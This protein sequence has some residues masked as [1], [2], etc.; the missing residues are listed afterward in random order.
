MVINN[1]VR[2]FFCKKLMDFYRWSYFGFRQSLDHRRWRFQKLFRHFFSHHSIRISKVRNE[3]RKSKKDAGKYFQQLKTSFL[4]AICPPT[5]TG[6]QPLS[7]L[8]FINEWLY[9]PS[10]VFSFPRPSWTGKKTLFPFQW[11]CLPQT[12]NKSARNNMSWTTCWNLSFEFWSTDFAIALSGNRLVMYFYTFQP[13]LPGLWPAATQTSPTTAQTATTTTTASSASTDVSGF[14]GFRRSQLCRRRN[15]PA[16]L[17]R[18]ETGSR[19][20][21]LLFG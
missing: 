1:T 2:S 17:H 9:Q 14:P 18:H 8:H 4:A 7:T 3:R 6:T 21:M 11:L 20:R 13:K 16:Q 12:L 5:L 10:Q 19:R 15:S